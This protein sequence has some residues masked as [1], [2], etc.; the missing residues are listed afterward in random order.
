[1]TSLA[2]REI[3]SPSNKIIVTTLTLTL[4]LLPALLYAIPTATNNKEIKIYGTVIE[5]QLV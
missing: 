3:F 5:N 1:M 2:S 4:T